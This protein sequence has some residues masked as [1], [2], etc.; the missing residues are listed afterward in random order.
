[1]PS[2]RRRRHDLD[3]LR[4]FTMLLGIALHARHRDSEKLS[5]VDVVVDALCDS[6][7]LISFLSYL[8]RP[9]ER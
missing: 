4:D 5:A 2:S 7:G 1:M 9:V 6:H 8:R 3:A